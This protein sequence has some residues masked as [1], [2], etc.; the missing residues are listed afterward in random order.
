MG[1]TLP[2]P[3]Q[4]TSL[5]QSAYLGDA[6]GPDADLDELLTIVVRREHDLSEGRGRGTMK[7]RENIKGKRGTMDHL[8]DLSYSS[9]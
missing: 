5:M 1:S 8:T 6:D 3:G 9:R 7:G 4:T 2:H